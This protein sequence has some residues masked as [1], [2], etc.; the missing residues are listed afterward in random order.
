MTL[1]AEPKKVIILVAIVVA[2]IA[3]KFYT[4]D[5]AAPAPARSAVTSTTASAIAP[6]F[7]TAATG[8]RPRVSGRGAATEFRLR[9]GSARPEDRPDPATIDPELRVDLLAKMQAIEPVAAGR[10]LFQFGAAP[11]PDKP[12]PGVPTGVPKIP[13]NQ[14]PAR[15]V[16]PPVMTGNVPPGVAHPPAAPINLRYYAYV[17]MKSSG[18]KIAYLL[19]G[20]DI[21]A[22]EENQLVKQRYRIVRIALS[23]IEIEDTQS[24]ST[25]TLRIMDVPA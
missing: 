19:D 10:N 7:P 2:G 17:V 22:A 8:T 4:S 15:P 9:Q 21:V 25:Q 12:L 23:T 3:L 14:P 1:G 20:D 6:A 13:V 24:K 16:P 18:R 11:A 5:D